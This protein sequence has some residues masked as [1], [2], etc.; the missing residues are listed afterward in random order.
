M[1]RLSRAALSVSFLV[2]AGSLAHAATFDPSQCRAGES[3]SACRA[4]LGASDA[5][6]SFQSQQGVTGKTKEGA[7]ETTSAVGEAAGEAGGA[8]GGLTGGVGEGLGE[9]GPDRFVRN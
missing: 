9:L 2:A 6:G 4:R 5:T 3:T 1:H 8:L 7:K